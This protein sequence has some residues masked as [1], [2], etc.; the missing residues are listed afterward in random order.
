MNPTQFLRLRLSKSGCNPWR[1]EVHESSC[2]ICDSPRF[3]KKTNMM[4][5]SNRI[6]CRLQH[7]F[8]ICFCKLVLRSVSFGEGKEP[9]DGLNWIELYEWFRVHPHHSEF[10]C[11][12]KQG[13][14]FCGEERQDKCHTL[15]TLVALTLIHFLGT[16]VEI[17]KRNF[18]QQTKFCEGK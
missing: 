15:G 6:G 13:W 10:I 1:I 18:F 17:F 14:S 5:V 7:S 9:P 16:N 3:V 4:N 12:H 2:Y 8:F 11:C